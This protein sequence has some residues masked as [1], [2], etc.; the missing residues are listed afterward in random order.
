MCIFI[1]AS[2][3]LV[4]A[5]LKMKASYLRHVSHTGTSSPLSLFYMWA[6][7]PFSWH[8][9]VGTSASHTGNE[10][11]SEAPPACTHI[12]IRM[13]LLEMT[14][15]LGNDHL[16]L[17]SSSITLKG[18][19]SQLNSGWKG[20]A[21]LIPLYCTCRRS[22]WKTSCWEA[23]V[24]TPQRGVK[25]CLL[26]ITVHSAAANICIWMRHALSEFCAAVSLC[27]LSTDGN[28]DKRE[29]VS[30]RIEQEIHL[31]KTHQNSLIWW[32]EK[33]WHEYRSPVPRWKRFREMKLVKS[34]QLLQCLWAFQVNGFSHVVWYALTHKQ[35]SLSKT[36][37]PT[38]PVSLSLLPRIICSSPLLFCP[39][40]FTFINQRIPIHPPIPLPYPAVLS[41]T[42]SKRPFSPLPPL[43]RT[44]F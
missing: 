34:Y 2:E 17:K 26:Q 9:H 13:W 22:A 43:V 27:L 3:A 11:V 30:W 25:T 37:Q 36:R 32:E 44:L 41:L 20:R 21:L 28:L 40:F 29:D 18:T 24:K 6:Q 15:S 35:N 38:L 7:R 12:F 14:G 10:L 33:R 23:A 4:Q 8:R 31:S 5:S 19:I 39:S 1:E 42:A 16:K